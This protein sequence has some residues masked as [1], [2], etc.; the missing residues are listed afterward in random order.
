[1][2]E[3]STHG[4]QP[5]QVNRRAFLKWMGALGVTAGAGA[6]AVAYGYN[7]EPHQIQVERVAVTLP[8]L[9]GA[10]DGMTIAHLSDLHLGPY[11]SEE[12]LHTAVQMTNALKPDVIVLT[13]DL[14]NSS[15]HYIQPCAEII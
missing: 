5:S 6:V 15:W 2:S 3:N 12:H 8:R 4:P 10:F 13:G 11:V 14:V 7:V 9:P 1:M